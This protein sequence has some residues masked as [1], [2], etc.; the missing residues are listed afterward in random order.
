M[1]RNLGSGFLYL[2]LVLIFIHSRIFEKKKRGRKK[3]WSFV[4]R[5][6]HTKIIML[7][8]E[9]AEVARRKPELSNKVENSGQD[10]RPSLC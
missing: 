6:A 9:L 5:N 8:T 7:N 4:I 3:L 1:I 2:N 10:S